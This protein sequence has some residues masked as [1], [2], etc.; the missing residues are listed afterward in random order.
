MEKIQRLRH[1]P[2]TF[3]SLVLGM[4]GFTLAVQRS[5]PLAGMGSLPSDW[6]LY[7]TLSIGGVS[8]LAYLLKSLL[9]PGEVAL[10][11]AH[12]VLINFF[13]LPAIV[14]LIF[15]AVFLV[16]DIETARYFFM[17]GV[18]LQFTSSVAIISS[19][20]SEPHYRI[21]H[22]TPAWFIPVIG[23]II[24]PLSGVRLGNLE[25]SWFFF[26]LGLVF[27]IAL[28]VIVMN[29]M[30]FHASIPE[31]FMPTLF[32]LFAPPALGFL[33]YLSLNGGQ[34]DAFA[35]ILYYFS[36]Y[37]F[38]L[39]LFR[40]PSL[41]RLEFHLSWWAYSFPIAARVLASVKMFA[42]T[43]NPFFRSIA[44]FELA[45]LAFVVLVLT[46]RTATAMVSG[47]VCIED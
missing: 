39:L 24:V 6:L 37:L 18:F 33:A 1:F 38:V 29:R 44:F 27:W 10:E 30:I 3:F 13:P 16:R 14:L 9:Y 40:L 5:M 17:V 22:M 23:S 35:R 7:L 12:P 28:F 20:M 4:A 42:L 34:L 43:E 15:S 21:S 8:V 11:W 36:L 31:R 41:S 32:I 25:L 45:F 2:V 46:I 47:R 26:S 19:W